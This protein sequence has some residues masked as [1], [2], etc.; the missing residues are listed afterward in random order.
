MTALRLKS[1][2]APVSFAAAALLLSAAA[3]VSTGALAADVETA[4]ATISPH[5]AERVGETPTMSELASSQAN[6]NALRAG[7][8]PVEQPRHRLPNGGL[9]S[10]PDQATLNALPTFAEPNA[11]VQ[12]K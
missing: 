4:P 1:C 11:G 7:G 10:A 12:S 5:V 3:L 9:T 8:S 2:P 6:R